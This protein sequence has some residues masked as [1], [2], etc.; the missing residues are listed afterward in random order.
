VI[1]RQKIYFTVS[2][3][4]NGKHGIPESH[5]GLNEHQHKIHATKI[6]QPDKERR[7]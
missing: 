2:L 4:K 1:I 5:A 3:E 6:G 7:G